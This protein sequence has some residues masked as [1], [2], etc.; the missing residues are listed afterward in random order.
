MIVKPDGP[1]GTASDRRSE[2]MGGLAK[3]LSIVEAFSSREFM[4]IADAARLS[5]ATRAAARSF[6]FLATREYE[7]HWRAE[8]PER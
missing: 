7:G 8:C 6:N 3:G 2:S 1:G 4:S 5:G